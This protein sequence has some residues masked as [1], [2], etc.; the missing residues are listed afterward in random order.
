MSNRPARK[1]RYVL[2]S[3]AAALALGVGITPTTAGAAGLITI[4][5]QPLTDTNRDCNG[6]PISAPTRNLG[7]TVM[8]QTPGFVAPTGYLITLV[9]VHDATPNATYDIRIIQEGP[10]GLV[11]SCYAVIG[12]VTTN[13]QGNGVMFAA[14]A[15]L[16]SATKWWV[17]LNNQQNFADYLDTD[18]VAIAS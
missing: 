4:S 15:V 9:I 7:F 14:T 6:A 12:K 5:K 8:V 16:A 3:V 11:G 10:A 18:L 2:A 17:D 1:H 13:S